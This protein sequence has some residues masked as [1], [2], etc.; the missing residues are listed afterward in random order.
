MDDRHAEGG[1]RVTPLEL[2]FD[3]VVVFAFTQ[4]TLYAAK[5]RGRDRV[6]VATGKEP[7]HPISASRIGSLPRGKGGVPDGALARS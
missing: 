5:S 3:L 7:W 1:P 2:Y 4:V 6:E